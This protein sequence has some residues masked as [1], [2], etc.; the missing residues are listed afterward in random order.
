MI[1]TVNYCAIISTRGFFQN[2]EQDILFPFQVLQTCS[3]GS[4]L[5]LL[6]ILQILASGNR[7]RMLVYLKYC[8][9]G[10]AFPP[11]ISL[12]FMYCCWIFIRN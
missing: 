7:Y 9:S 5:V 8:F 11:G 12:F 10:L 6:R 2:N 1:L 4:F 3:T